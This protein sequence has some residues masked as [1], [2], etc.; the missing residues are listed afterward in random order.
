LNIPF[1]VT[2]QPARRDA[3]PD[4]LPI[5][6]DLRESG[7]LEQDAHNVIVLYPPIGKF[8][9]EWTGD[10][11]TLVDKQREGMT[12]AVPVRYSERSLTFEERS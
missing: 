12:G 1:I 7:N 8:N 5:M 9:G 3:D 11:Q 4:R 6:Q 2:S 10:G